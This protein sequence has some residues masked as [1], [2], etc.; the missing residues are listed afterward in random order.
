MVWEEDCILLG[1]EAHS[2]LWA[3]T[4]PG[5]KAPQ[6]EDSTLPRLFHWLTLCSAKSYSELSN[7]N[8]MRISEG[9]ELF[10]NV[11]APVHS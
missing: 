11:F 7:E 5:H 3:E 9:P 4:V 6:I 10:T 8:L 1:K 2:F